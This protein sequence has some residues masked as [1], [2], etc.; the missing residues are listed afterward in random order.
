M[1]V[2]DGRARRIEHIVKTEPK[3]S[4]VSIEKD[5]KHKCEAKKD[6]VNYPVGNAKEEGKGDIGAEDQELGGDNIQINRS[7]EVPLFSQKDE[8]AVFASVAHLEKRS[9]EFA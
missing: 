6:W 4:S 2:L 9:I 3:T 8:T 7:N 5:R 1:R